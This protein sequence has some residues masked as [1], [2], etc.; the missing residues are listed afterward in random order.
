MEFNNLEDDE[1]DFVQDDSDVEEDQV[2]HYDEHSWWKEKDIP[3]GFTY[4]SKKN[5]FQKSM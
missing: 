3:V 4:K 1:H 2:K 5:R